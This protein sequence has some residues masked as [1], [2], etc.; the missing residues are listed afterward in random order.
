MHIEI[1]PDSSSEPHQL[2]LVEVSQNL[3]QLESSRETQGEGLVQSGSTARTVSKSQS[4]GTPESYSRFIHRECA[5]GEGGRAPVGKNQ[6]IIDIMK[7]GAPATGWTVKLKGHVDETAVAEHEVKKDSTPPPKLVTATVTDFGMEYKYTITAPADQG[8]Y[9]RVACYFR[10]KV[11][12]GWVP[13]SVEV[14]VLGWD[15]KDSSFETG[16][17]RNL[18]KDLEGGQFAAAKK[19]CEEQHR[20]AWQ[21]GYWMK[22][23]LH[24]FGAWKQI[25]LN[26]KSTKVEPSD[27][28][29]GF[30][31]WDLFNKDGK[32]APA[33]EVE[34]KYTVDEE[35]NAW[36]FRIDAITVME[37][38]GAACY[39]TSV[40]WCKIVFN[41]G[42]FIGGAVLLLLLI[43]GGVYYYFFYSASDE[44]GY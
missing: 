28:S 21:C 40:T 38:E 6:K 23:P 16:G 7:E 43:G 24:G 27:K 3:T 10:V 20:T 36:K 17:W 11:I 42:W 32:F 29:G 44:F 25:E 1:H 8:A 31:S 18:N 39:K 5:L 33:W 13:G 2:D 26:I 4:T 37:V 12:D 19:A 14:N 30:A 15:G 34:T 22:I 9:D 35:K 41:K